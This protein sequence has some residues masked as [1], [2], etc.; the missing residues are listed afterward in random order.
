[1]NYRFGKVKEQCSGADICWL[2]PLLVKSDGATF[3]VKIKNHS[4]DISKTQFQG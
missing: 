3:E 2:L 1:M 4:Q